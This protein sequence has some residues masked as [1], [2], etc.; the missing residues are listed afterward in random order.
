MIISGI[1]SA[2]T[3]PISDQSTQSHGD[4]WKPPIVSVAVLVTAQHTYSIGPIDSSPSVVHTVTSPT[5]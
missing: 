4:F 1:L 5:R 2:C 3:P